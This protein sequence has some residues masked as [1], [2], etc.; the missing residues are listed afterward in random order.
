MSYYRIREEMSPILVE[1][2]KLLGEANIYRKCFK[3]ESN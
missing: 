1:I 2:K 3:N